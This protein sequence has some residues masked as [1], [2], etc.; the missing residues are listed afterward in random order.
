MSKQMT[1]KVALSVMGL[2]LLIWVLPV[3]AETQAYPELPLQEMRLVTYTKKFAKLMG[4]PIPEI[5]NE[6]TGGLEAVEFYI[7]ETNRSKKYFGYFKL[8]VNSELPIQFPEKADRGDRE[9]FEDHFF[10][11]NSEDWLKLPKEIRIP[12][13]QLDSP[14]RMKAFIAS[15]NYKHQKK[16]FFT[17]IDYEEYYNNLLPG[18]H[19]I[20]LSIPPPFSKKTDEYGPIGIWLLRQKLPNENQVLADD[21]IYLKFELPEDFYQKIPEYFKKSCIENLRLDGR[22]KSAKRLCR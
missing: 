9:L 15:M 5:G 22:A 2:V 4:L 12:F 16:G 1:A 6:P 13:G 11:R 7:K 19:Y 18:L 14:Y 3:H 21:S 17:S 8:Y 20:K 10:S